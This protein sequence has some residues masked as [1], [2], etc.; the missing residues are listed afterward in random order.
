V[1]TPGHIIWHVNQLGG[2]IGDKISTN[3]TA[4]NY[5]EISLTLKN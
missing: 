2:L 4:D 1:T 5:G 3:P